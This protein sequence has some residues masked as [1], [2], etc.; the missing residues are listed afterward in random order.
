[1]DVKGNTILITGGATGIGLALAEAFLA[2]GNEVIVCARTEAN[3][4]AAKE[5]FPRL[6]TLRCDLSD[7]KERQRLHD[8]VVAD[9]P[10]LNILINNAGIQRMVDFR[11]GPADLLRHRAAD[12]EDE[13]EINLRAAVH[14][15]ALFVPD[16]MKKK[17]AAV[18]NV[19]SGLGFA[20]LA[21]MPV[22]CATKA[23][24]HSFTMSLRRQLRD[25]PVRVFELIPPTTDTNIDK[26]ARSARGQKD[27]GIQPAEVAKEALSGF[28][29]DE[30][31]IAFG[32]A[33]NLIGGSRADPV[34]LFNNMNR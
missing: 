24:L 17:A 28:A 25:T 12:G 34:Q 31:E 27:R 4:K 16:L 1:M 7:E 22:Y 26:G 8:R 13:I 15:T 30:Y 3:L 21:F 20:P 33:K 5:R 14:L 10:A 29:A 23:A 9:F 32:M 18:I 11:D 2:E 6:H 19:S